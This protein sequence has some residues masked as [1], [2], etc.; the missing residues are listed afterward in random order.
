MTGGVSD[1]RMGV[2]RMKQ[3]KKTVLWK[4][5]TAVGAVAGLM[6]AAFLLFLL[7]AAPNGDVLQ[8]R[9]EDGFVRLEGVA[10]RERTEEAAPIGVAVDY[11]VTVV[12]DLDHDVCL[13]FYAVHQ[14]AQVRLDGELIYSRMPQ[15]GG[16]VVQTPGS[17]WAMIPVYR[18]DAGKEICV[19]VYPVYESFRDREV[20]LLLGSDLAMYRDR[21]RKDL[22]VLL[23]SGLTMLVGLVYLGMA[24]YYL[25]CGKSGRKLLCI[26]M[27]GIFLGIWRFADTR[28]SPFF[29]PGNTV[30]LYYVSLC[31]LMFSILPFMKS[32]KR[33][34]GSRWI[35]VF[36]LAAAVAMIVQMGLQ[37]FWGIDLRRTLILTHGFIVAGALLLLGAVIRQWIGTSHREETVRERV[38]LLI[39]LGGV[40]MDTAAFF[41]RRTSSG[42]LFTLIAFLA[43]VAV[44]GVVFIL[45][46]NRKER[47]LT[48]VRVT[49]TMSQ[50]RSHFIFN[51]LNA[52]SGMCKYDPEKADRTIVSF[53][54]YLRANIDVLQEDQP[55]SFRTSLRQVEDYVE[56]EKIRFGDK[57]R[58][59][60][61]IGEDRFVMPLLIL[62]PIVENAIKHGILPRPE[63]GTITLTTWRTAE[64]VRISVTDDGVGFDP[65][66]TPDRSSVGLKNVRFRL[67]YLMNGRL[68][69]ESAPGRG[70]TIT[71]ILPAAGCREKN[72]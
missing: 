56:L 3:E 68:E 26:G 20:E 15:E 46:Y 62:Q 18:E 32:Q 37:L 44:T 55:V 58:F 23:T 54:R 45:D 34:E 61:E 59:V 49:T 48:E 42:I 70:T 66:E 27:F 64:D 16:S 40:L 2:R 11:S 50:I 12:P 8:P 57:I 63:G 22:P 17:Y 72:G 47:Q 7:I 4:L 65:E 36:C 19:S 41:I 6:M 43:Y 10:R 60:E 28:F 14:Y 38:M 53:A 30:F 39:I 69:L 13:G 33:E 21:L 52:I 35:D 67:Q 71:V 1:D 51:V 29:H 5:S 25:A 31:A 24:L 9:T